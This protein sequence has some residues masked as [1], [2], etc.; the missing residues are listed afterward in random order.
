MST[1]LVQKG[2]LNVGDYVL[3]GS[4]SGKVKALLNER[5]ET[6]NDRVVTKPF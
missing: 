5:G 2:T 1:I 4:F 3:A 6:R